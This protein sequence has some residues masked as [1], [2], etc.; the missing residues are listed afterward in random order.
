M[1]G[2]AVGDALGAPAEFKLPGTF[3]TID[4]MI[5]G[6]LFRL[7]PGQW[8]DDTSMALCLAESLIQRSGFDAVDQLQRYVRWYREGYLS[9]TGECF[10]IGMN[11]Q[12]ALL[13][14]EQTGEARC[15]STD[16]MS[17]GNGCLMRLAP[18]PLAFAMHPAHAISFAAESART[19]HGAVSSIDAC[20]YL[21]ALIVGALRGVSK[22]EL[23]APFYTPIPGYWE[24]HPLA[25]EVA[26]VASGSFARK[27]PPAIAGAGFAVRSLEAA[28]WAFARTP[29]FRAGAIDAIN[30]GDDAD[31]T[32]AIFGQLA[33]AF[34]GASRIPQEWRLLLAQRD[35]IT[36]YADGLH[37]LA[38]HPSVAADGMAS[39]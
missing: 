13:R 38:T 32:G 17:A 6:G 24:Q 36:Q 8:T 28:L 2:L 22:D 27:S 7:A 23:L 12:A 4:A 9:S 19:T 15:G 25:P 29:D 21:A 18:V 1:I 5:G 3:P 33:G 39:A 26:E 37:A 35:V 30:L 16:P 20:R 10:D 31:T 14:F 34:Y 11:V